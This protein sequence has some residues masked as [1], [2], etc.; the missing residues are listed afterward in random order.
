MTNEIK[1]LS[2]LTDDELQELFRSADLVT[3]WTVG[4]GCELD[5]LLAALEREI[6]RRF[7]KLPDCDA[8]HYI[9]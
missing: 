9:I 1:L 8:L 3:S 2:S 4:S 7:C 5:E 6:I